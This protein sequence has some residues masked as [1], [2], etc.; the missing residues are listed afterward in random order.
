MELG[1]SKGARDS[2]KARRLLRQLAKIN[3]ELSYVVLEE[4]DGVTALHVRDSIITPTYV[5]YGV[6]Q[7]A[8]LTRIVAWCDELGVPLGGAFLDVGAN[9]GT[10]TLYAMRSGRF[11]RALCLEPAPENVRL[12]ELNVELN[13][14]GDKV[15]VLPV[16][17]AAEAGTA[18]LWLT[19]GNKGDHRLADDGA[20]PS[21]HS[22]AIEVETITLDAAIARAHIAPSDVSLAWVDTQGH[23]LGVLQGAETIIDSGAAFCMEFWPAEYRRIGV[24]EALVDLLCTRFTHF[25][26]LAEPALRLRP[27]EE[28]RALAAAFGDT[29]QTDL[30]LLPH[31]VR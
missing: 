27:A 5:G 19:D 20:A 18:K 28:V 8:E 23:E 30:F 22:G 6:F 31:P 15:T 29:G 10:S 3:P 24:Y 25:A 9:V 16:A 26:D 11:D 14:L 21:S 4:P 2:L 13:H 7:R 1:S 12:T 17:C